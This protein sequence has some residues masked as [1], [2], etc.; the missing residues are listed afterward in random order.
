MPTQ[1]GKHFWPNFSYVRGIRIDYLSPTLYVTDVLIF[2][3]FAFSIFNFK[4]SI[5]S[6][7]SI[8]KLALITAFLSVGIV[9]S[10][11]P[12]SGFY[13]LLKLL[14]FIFLGFYTAANFKNLK[15]EIVLILFLTGILFESLLSIAQFINH[16]SLQGIFYFFGERFFNSQTPGIAN[17][18]LNGALVLRPYGTF[19]HP[20]V[21]AGYLAIAMAIAIS[22]L[23]NNISKIRRIFYF[24]SIAIGTVAIFLTLSRIATVLWIVLLAYSLIYAFMKQKSKFSFFYFLFSIFALVLAISMFVISSFSFRFTSIHFYD[25]S[26]VQRGALI[27]DSLA[28][29]KKHPVFGVGLN[30]FL[31]NLPT[32]EKLQP[33]HNIFFLVLAETGFLGLGLF[34]WFLIKTFKRIINHESVI[35]SMLIILSSILVL[36][37]FDHY[38]LTLQQGQLLFSFVLGLCWAKRK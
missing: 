30:N 24:T 10:K 9:F 22:N 4:F 11:S 1:L 7:F 13:G 25:E 33:V 35:K 38:F 26:V 28:M 18:S 31:A 36:G 32:S 37:M 21:L 34:I 19:S 29:I 17:V 14:E 23:K 16:G 15:K 12:T 5:K 2:L 3:F 27:K 6:K 20:N 8:S